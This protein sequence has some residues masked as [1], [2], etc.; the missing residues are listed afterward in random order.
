MG[1]GAPA[2]QLADFCEQEFGSAGALLGA[3]MLQG[4]E[5]E[6]SFSGLR[7][8]QLAELAAELPEVAAAIKKGRFDDI[9]QTQ[10]G[11]RWLEEFGAYLSDYGWRAQTWSDIRSPTWAEDPKLPQS[12]IQRYLVDPEHAPAVAQAR[13]RV[14]REATIRDIEERMPDQGKRAKFRSLLEAAQAHVPTS[15]SRANW[16][17]RIVGVLRLPIMALGRKFAEA[18]ILEQAEDIFYVNLTEL[19]DLAHG[20]D[21][22]AVRAAIPQRRIDLEHWELLVPPPTLGRRSGSGRPSGP[23]RYGG[24]GLQ[25]SDEPKIVNGNAASQGTARGRACVILKLDDASRLET[26]DVLVCPS[27]APT[28]TPLFAIAAAVVTDAGGMLSHSAILAREYAIPCVAGT[29]IG[30][31]KI[32]DGALVVV[33]GTR[34]TVHIEE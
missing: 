29:G 18:G 31:Q 22:E 14:Q 9:G 4:I 5:N 2:D 28:W 10:G 33:D 17:N 20:G 1:F 8:S 32:P 13:A 21:P 7:L 25:L 27:T 30:T 16:Q 23:D 19:H 11:Q 15:E 3:T 12:L 6:S 24:G 26:G 34:G